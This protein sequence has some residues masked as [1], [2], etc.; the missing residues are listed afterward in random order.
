GEPGSGLSRLGGLLAMSTRAL[1]VRRGRV[2]ARYESRL[3]PDKTR[4]PSSPRPTSPR[5]DFGTS[6]PIRL[7]LGVEAPSTAGFGA[8]V[9]TGV[10]SREG[11]ARIQV[12]A[13][14]DTTR[15]VFATSQ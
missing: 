12:C 13:L 3:T 8:G 1:T 2:S 9:S 15:V 4:P 6:L 10:T 14:T 5:R 11:D 7:R